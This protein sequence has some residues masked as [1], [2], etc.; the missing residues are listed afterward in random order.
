MNA[1]NAESP[2]PLYHQL[3]ASLTEEILA[4]KYPVGSRIPSEPE[5]AR[6]YAIGRPTV[7]QATDLLVRQRRVQ[8][9][10]GSGTFV[11]EKPEQ[12]DVLSL[13]GTMASLKKTGSASKTTIVERLRQCRV[14]PEEDHN[15]FA[16]QDAWFFRRVSRVKTRPVLIEALWLSTDLF[17]DLGKQA[18]A[19]RSLSQLASEHY[20]LRASSAD[21]SFSIVRADER[22]AQ[23]LGVEVNE[24]LLLVKRRVHF[25]Q[26]QNAV[27]SE[28]TCRT[29]QLEFCQTVL[30]NNE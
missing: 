20:D 15:P 26:A 17:K 30:V 6:R 22:S 21:Q 5:L 8:R 11:I 7:R 2:V 24:P 23:W 18:L 1:L 16:N 29:D 27:Y 14:D 28:L 3:A 10:R 19:G 13:A 25:P 9:R 12:L 4:G